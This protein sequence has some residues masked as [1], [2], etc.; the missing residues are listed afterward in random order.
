[1]SNRRPEADWSGHIGQEDPSLV[2]RIKVL[3]DAMAGTS[4]TDLELTE[5]AMTIVLRRRPLQVVQQRLSAASGNLPAPPPAAPAEMTLAVMA[6]I[7]GVFYAT[8][9]PDSPPFVQ[10]GDIVK[11]GQVVCLVEAMK[12]FNEIKTEIGGT[13]V[14]IPPKNNQLVKK[15]DPLVRIKPT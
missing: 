4:I 5:G 9:S 10:V 11:R 7:T 3:A 2:E 8:T 13:V 12:V 14:A 6:P 15:G 1:V